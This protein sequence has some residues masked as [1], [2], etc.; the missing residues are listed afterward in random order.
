MNIADKDRSSDAEMP[1][2]A[3]LPPMSDMQDGGEE[4]QITEEWMECVK[5]SKWRV[6]PRGLSAV[7]LLVQDDWN[8]SDGET[9]RTTGLSCDVVADVEENASNDN[10][11]LLEL[12]DCHV[13]GPI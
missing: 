1:P 4:S 5:C 6:L 8:C 12:S 9:W 3:T 10:E 7:T 11:T 13:L 2:G